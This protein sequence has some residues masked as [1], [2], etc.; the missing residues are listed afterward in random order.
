M[1]SLSDAD[2]LHLWEGGLRRHPLD[3]A[4]LALSAAFPETPYEHLADWPLG[5]RNRALV[6]LRCNCFGQKLQGWTA[7]PSCAEKLEFELDGRVIA[8]AGPS[9]QSMSDGLGQ[10]IVVERSTFRLPTS[11]DL[12]SVVKETDPRLAAIRLV[13][14]CRIPS[15]NA[16]ATS[17]DDVGF[18][19]DLGDRHSGSWSDEELEEIGEQMALADPLAETRLTLHCPKCEVDWEES[20]DMTS[21][22]WAEIDACVRRLLLEIHTLASAYGWTETEILSL[23]E[24]RRVRYVEMVQS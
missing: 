17:A 12:A 3:R 19:T 18:T 16:E 4:L 1:R 2:L 22:L 9:A 11:R 23:G 15:A 13:E 24:N 20:L 7:C 10:P 14:N 21:F 8:D 6:E 5:R